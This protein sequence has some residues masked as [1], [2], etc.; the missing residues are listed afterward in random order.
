MKLNNILFKGAVA[1]CAMLISASCSDSYLDTDPTEFLDEDAVSEVLQQDES[2]VV[3]L[4]TG[5]YMNFYNGGDYHTRHDDF[6]FP[7]IVITTNLNCEDIAYWRDAH[8]FCYDYQLDNRLGNYARTASMWCQLYQVIDN[9][10]DII[11]MLKPTDS[12]PVPS[13]N[14]LKSML[15][16]AYGLRAYC[17]FWLVN[18]WQQPLSEGADQLGVPLKTEDVYR[19][20]RV[21]VGEI[22]EQI[23]DD[24]DNAYGYLQ[25][26]GIS[27]KG[28]LSEYSVA[29]IYANVLMFMGNY[30]DAAKY[31]EEAIKGGSLNSPAEMMSGFNS[32]DM[33][34][35]LWGYYVNN[36]T[37]G[38]YAS[39]FS[40]M[41][42]YFIGYGGQVGYRKLIASNLYDQIDDNDV[43]KGWFGYNPAF[44]LLPVS[45]SFENSA[46]FENYIAGKFRD[47][48]MTSGGNDDP[49]TSDII[50]FRTAE[51]YYLAAEAYYLNN[52]PSKAQAKL[53]EIM[54][55]RLAGYNCGLSGQALYDEIC[56]QKR[57]DMWGEVSRYLDAKRR[58]EMIDRSKSVNIAADLPYYD[59]VTYSARDYRMI[60]RIPTVEM[61]NNPDIPMSDDNK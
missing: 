17:Y 56:L 11:E 58:G 14:S 61:Q 38:Y 57:V 27:S 29:A 48:Y 30:A 40:H 15:G 2:R 55:T 35:V 23:V 28:N 5:A 52:E 42:S 6:G 50:Y 46:H 33:S 19:P 37:T 31:A 53:N 54:S 9:S 8:F 13:S 1:A 59:A 26:L 39:F 25:G 16:Q 60:Y 47:K 18:L 12:R 34:E 24:L 32:L 21:P 3:A 49:F 45:Y 7:A 41:D 51:M 22:Y 10:N 44:N 20:E 4:I 43:R 36:E